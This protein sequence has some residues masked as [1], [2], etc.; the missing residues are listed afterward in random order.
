MDNQKPVTAEDVAKM[1]KNG[2]IMLGV[3]AGVF[4]LIVILTVTTTGG[5]PFWMIFIVG[6]SL[7]LGLIELRKAKKAEAGMHGAAAPASAPETVTPPPS[8]P[9]EPPQV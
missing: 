6:V 8:T 1:K 7:A 3:A 9:S 4:A 2:K 5:A